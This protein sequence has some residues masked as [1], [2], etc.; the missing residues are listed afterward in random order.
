MILVGARDLGSVTLRLRPARSVS[1]A[2][3]DAA[4]IRNNRPVDVQRERP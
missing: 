1:A 4:L 2:D 3:R